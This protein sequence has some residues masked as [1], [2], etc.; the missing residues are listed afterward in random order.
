MS[1]PTLV[2]VACMDGSRSIIM[3]II[4]TYNNNKN[5]NIYCYSCN[6]CIYI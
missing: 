2:D 1:M 3:I 6:Y 5:N 4:I